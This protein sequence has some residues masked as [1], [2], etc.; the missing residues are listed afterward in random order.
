MQDI[1]RAASRRAAGLHMG[2]AEPLDN[3]APEREA[4]QARATTEGKDVETSVAR[5]PADGQK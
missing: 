3:P 4:E 1:Y 2:P 5:L